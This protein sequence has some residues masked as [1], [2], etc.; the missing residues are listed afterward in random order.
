[1]IE[2][3]SSVQFVE[4]SEVEKKVLEMF[5]EYAKDHDAKSERDHYY[6]QRLDL[7]R[8]EFEQSFSP[9]E[10]VPAHVKLNESLEFKGKHCKQETLEMIQEHFGAIAMQALKKLRGESEDKVEFTG[11][12]TIYGK[13]GYE[14]TDLAGFIYGILYDL[15][16]N[17]G[18]KIETMYTGKTVSP[19]YKGIIPIDF[20]DW[21]VSSLYGA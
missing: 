11:K 2:S 12:L 10:I 9:F 7:L 5:L 14:T 15:P 19:L 4:E 20:E 1:M 8:T 13:K 6:S 21:I 17:D 18:F 16:D 3:D